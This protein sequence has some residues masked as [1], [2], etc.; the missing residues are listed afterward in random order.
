MPESICIFFLTGTHCKWCLKRGLGMCKRNR[1]KRGNKAQIFSHK[2]DAIGLKIHACSFSQLLIVNLIL[3]V[4]ISNQSQ[5]WSSKGTHSMLLHSFDY[6]FLSSLTNIPFLSIYHFWLY[7]LTALCFLRFSPLNILG[8]GIFY[9]LFRLL[10]KIVWR[11]DQR[12][13]VISELHAIYRVIHALF[14]FN[15]FVLFA[16]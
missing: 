14:L 10:H 8:N 9:V 5:S 7:F 4:E 11:Y 15:P 6:F 1:S 2:V 16:S 13:H 3:N 12:Y